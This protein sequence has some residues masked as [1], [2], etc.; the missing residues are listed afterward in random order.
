MKRFRS[1]QNDTSNLSPALIQLHVERR[2]LSGVEFDVQQKIILILGE[3]HFRAS[4]S[5]VV[6]FTTQNY[7]SMSNLSSMSQNYASMS[8]LCQTLFT[9]L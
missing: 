2:P 8:S 5:S 7:A 6:T 1:H 4:D 9:L 3:S